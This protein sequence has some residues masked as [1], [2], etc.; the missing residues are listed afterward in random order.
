V[1]VADAQRA[2]RE[3]HLGSAAAVQSL[4]R[5]LHDLTRDPAQRLRALDVALARMGLVEEEEDVKLLAATPRHTAQSR[6]NPSLLE[7]TGGTVDRNEGVTHKHEELPQKGSSSSLPELQPEGQH[8]SSSLLRTQS[9]RKLRR[10]FDAIDAG[11]VFLERIEEELAKQRRISERYVALA[12][13]NLGAA[14]GER[15]AQCVSGSSK[16]RAQG[17]AN[18]LADKLQLQQSRVAAEARHLRARIRSALQGDA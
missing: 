15:D 10:Q 9:D 18:E 7:Q 12:A 11:S 2:A 6:S 14:D 13:E 3:H 1:Q 16:T 17:T 8:S 5:V 4:R